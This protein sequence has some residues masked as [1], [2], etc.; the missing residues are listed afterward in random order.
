MGKHQQ[1]ADVLIMTEMNS[2]DEDRLIAGVGYAVRQNDVRA[3]A[4]DA[5]HQAIDEETGRYVQLLSERTYRPIHVFPNGH[6]SDIVKNVSTIADQTEDEEM[7]ILHEKQHKDS[8]LTWLG[9][10]A[11]ILL[12][13]ISIVV[14]MNM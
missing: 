7:A 8:Q 11:V 6:R 3:W 12:L 1:R 4:L 9:I 5:D 14:L 13:V 2:V 10:I